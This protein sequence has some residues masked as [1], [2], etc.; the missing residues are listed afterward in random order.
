[1][2]AEYNLTTAILRQNFQVF[3]GEVFHLLNPS[4][5]FKNNW[6]L[7]AIARAVEKAMQRKIK[8]LI[9]NLPPR[10]LK[11][12][13]ASVA[14]P[15]FILGHDPS[16]RILCVHYGDELA[17]HLS[18]WT[19]SVMEAPW[20][21]STFPGTKIDKGKQTEEMINTTKGGYRFARPIFGPMTGFGARYIIC[22][23]PSKA[24]DVHSPAMREKV[25]IAF[26]EGVLTRLDDPKNDVVI[27]VTQRLHED[28][29]VARL[30]AVGGWAEL[31]I[32]AETDIDREYDIGE[33]K[34]HIF[35]AGSVLD[36]NRMSKADLDQRRKELGSAGYAAQYLQS[37]IAG[38]G[39]VFDWKWFKPYFYVDAISLDYDFLFHSYD[40]ASSLGPNSSYSV[41]T[42]WG[43]VGDDFYLIG[44]MRERISMPDLVK[45]ALYLYEKDKPDLVLVETAGIGSALF[46]TLREKF[47]R[48]IQA[49]SPDNDKV[50]RAEAVSPLIEA[51]HVYVRPD[52]AY[53]EVFRN[54]VIAFPNSKYDDQVD[55]MTQMLFKGRRAIQFVL[56]TAMRRR[57]TQIDESKY[58][59]QIGAI[60]LGGA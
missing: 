58:L 4:Q 51:G 32:P 2:N 15:A 12:T 56:R 44:V 46:Q 45:K 16:A 24:V 53:S 27:V 10:H 1:M 22:D 11:S 31:V 26:T 60:L 5:H 39:T 21:R 20:Y 42:S 30:R 47:G 6:H 19:R 36:P 14:L 8:R 55:S 28:D 37:P 25:W 23:D 40:V 17:T 54:E 50:T 34:T 9:I 52:A 57:E 18:N 33:G 38:G 41:C 3:A 59:A 48:R 7:A 13:I 49:V 35:E 43:V 29:L